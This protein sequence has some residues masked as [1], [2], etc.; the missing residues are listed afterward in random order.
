[1]STG[2]I[3]MTSTSQ[4]M[5]AKPVGTRPSWDQVSS[6]SRQRRYRFVE[7]QII[8]QPEKPDGRAYRVLGGEVL[9][10]RSGHPVDL[11]ESGEYLDGQVWP[12]AVALA[13]TDCDLAIIG[14]I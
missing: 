14:G 8:F 5:A 12:G 10:L 3:G 7:G 2:T 13:R 11:V 9:I 1:M 4:V 6:L